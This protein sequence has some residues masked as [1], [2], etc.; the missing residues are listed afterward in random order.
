MESFPKGDRF[1]VHED[2]LN[3]CV[4]PLASVILAPRLSLPPGVSVAYPI[5]RPPSLCSWTM[6]QQDFFLTYAYQ[7]CNRLH[8][9]VSHLHNRVLRGHRCQ[10]RVQIET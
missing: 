3:T 5:F 8:P 1:V 10:A 7:V 6:E 2:E 4:P 9:V